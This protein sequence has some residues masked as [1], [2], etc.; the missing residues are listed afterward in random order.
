MS[1]SI[2]PIAWASLAGVCLLM[3]GSTAQAQTANGSLNWAKARDVTTEKQLQTQVSAS[4]PV[5]DQLA[6][7]KLPGNDA[8]ATSGNSLYTKSIILYDGEMFTL[9][10]VGSV[11]HL[12]AELRNR[13][14]AAPRG[15]F[16]LWPNFLK[17]N[18]KW[19]AGKEVPLKMAKGDS[20]LAEVVLK[21]VA[22]SRQVLISLY[23]QCPISVLEAPQPSSKAQQ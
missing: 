3:L 6:S 22:G 7:M 21:E 20:R 5:L 10:P 19:L 2:I 18:S 17:R 13:V 23:R 9:V 1:T 4:R 16:T 15:D 11:L 12:P 8:P 14:I